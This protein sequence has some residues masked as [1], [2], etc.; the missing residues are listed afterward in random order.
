M[1]LRFR[2]RFFSWFDSYDVYDENGDA[3][4]TVEG[5]LS[6]GH[7]LVIYDRSGNEVGMIKE[8]VF[9]WLPKFEMYCGDRYMGMIRKSFTFFKDEFD[10]DCNGW[11]VQGD[12]WDWNYSIYSRDGRKVADISKELFHF[13]D[14]YNLYIQ[15][16]GDA[17][18]VLM[19]VLAIDAEKCSSG[20]G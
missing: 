2:Q 12:W 11:H 8:K 18:C 13:T 1:I 14:T 9:T 20:N 19:V 7:R 15:N 5:K 4:F 3:F 6:W 16:P 17:L 10:L